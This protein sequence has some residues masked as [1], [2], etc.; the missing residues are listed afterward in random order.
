MADGGALPVTMYR[1]EHGEGFSVPLVQLRNRRVAAQPAQHWIFQRTLEWVLFGRRELSSGPI[2]KILQTL[3]MESTTLQINKAAVTNNLITKQEHDQ[4]MSLFKQQLT[5]IDPCSLG[6]IRTSTL[7]PLSV[8]AAVCRSF[9]RSPGATAFLTSFSQPIPEAWGLLDQRDANDANMEEDLALNDQI[10]ELNFEVEDTTFAQELVTSMAEFKTDPADDERMKTYVLQRVRR[11]S[12]LSPPRLT[13][14]DMI[15]INLL[16]PHTYRCRAT[17]N[18]SSTPTSS[19]APPPL[20]R[21]VRVVPYSTS[22]RRPTRPIFFASWD[23]W[24]RPIARPMTHPSR[25]P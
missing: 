24:T 9:G 4:L 2:W 19:I 10:D 14:A 6:R 11:S 12:S 25:C 20:P 21:D 22:R 17:S 5:H 3:S 16:T 8:A 7:L 18:M 13:N 23:T 15:L 1:V